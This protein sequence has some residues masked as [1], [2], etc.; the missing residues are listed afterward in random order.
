MITKD[1]HNF[2]PL[3]MLPW[4]QRVCLVM[5]LRLNRLG[6]TVAV[7]YTISSVLASSAILSLTYTYAGMYDGRKVH[8]YY[9]I[10]FYH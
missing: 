2:A 7:Y 5:I 1:V 9:Q 4:Q 3:Y 6:L 8:E 10:G